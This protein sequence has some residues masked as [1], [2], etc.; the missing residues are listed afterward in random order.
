M[1]T[2]ILVLDIYKK[3][4]EYGIIGDI[5][6]MT[7]GNGEPVQVG[8][9]V[10]LENI[11]EKSMKGLRFAEKSDDD[12]GIMG[13]HGHQFVNGISDNDEWKITLAKKFYDVQVGD[14][15]DAGLV[16]DERSYYVLNI[17][18]EEIEFTKSEIDRLKNQLEEL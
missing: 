1:A 6:D 5:T 9:L 14:K 17:K 10:F 12:Y 4:E 3:G 11:R 15:D 16:L 2:R 8:D 13:V 7:Y 18:N